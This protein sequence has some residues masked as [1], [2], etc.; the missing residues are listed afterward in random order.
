M[1]R[2]EEKRTWEQKGLLAVCDGVEICSRRVVARTAE[3]EGTTV[4]GVSEEAEVEEEA[5]G[6]VGS[7][8]W[9]C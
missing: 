3:E 9:S 4:G 8:D 6:G 2:R 1:K 5:V 7:R